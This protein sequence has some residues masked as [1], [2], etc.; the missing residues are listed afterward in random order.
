MGAFNS[1]TGIPYHE[2]NLKTG[3]AGNPSWNAEYSILS[4]IGSV[5]LEFKALSHFSGDP[6]Y[7]AAADRVMD[8][9]IR[10][11]HET[12][13]GLYPVYISPTSGAFRDSHVTMGALADSFY[14]YL[15]KQWLLT[16]K[17]EPKF[18][19]MYD[20]AVDGMTALLLTKSHPS[21]LLFVGEATNGQ[22]SNVFDHLMCFV[23][24]MLALGSIHEPDASRASVHLGLAKELAN[25]C[26]ALYSRSPSGL[27]PDVVTFNTRPTPGVTDDFRIK[28][29]NYLLRPETLESLYILH[30]ITKD[31]MYKEQAWSI[32]LAIQAHCKTESAY[33]GV[34]D[35]GSKSP[36]KNNSM[37]S[38]FL[39]ETLKYLYLMFANPPDQDLVPLD[40][41]VFNTE[42][43]PLP[44]FALQHN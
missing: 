16:G 13:K 25:T 10:H 41:F 36:P 15:L 5:Q 21:G 24:G 31:P 8:T 28:S 30:S 32:F 43:H 6:K 40:Q 26:Y 4:E 17:E 27:A 9:L 1:P 37:Q 42:A 22:K 38:F 7:A 12:E 23:P 33:S 14:E 18:K 20:D 44:I 39:A 29:S 2:V 11:A 35:V 19:K 34:V 3:K